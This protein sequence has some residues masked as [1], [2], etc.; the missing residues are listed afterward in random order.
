VITADT[1]MMYTPNAVEDVTPEQI[2]NYLWKKTNGRVFPKTGIGA[3][4][5]LFGKIYGIRPEVL[6]AQGTQEVGFY[7]NVS[8]NYRWVKNNNPAE[9]KYYRGAFDPESAPPWLN[10]ENTFAVFISKKHGIKSH[11]ER[12]FDYMPY[13]PNTTVRQFLNRWGTSH[14]SKVVSRANEILSQPK[15]PAPGVRADLTHRAMSNLANRGIIRGYEG[16]ML[17]PEWPLTRAEMAA[18]LARTFS[19]KLYSVTPAPAPSDVVGHWARNDI[20]LIIGAGWMGGYPD[21]TF[22]PNKEITRAEVCSILHRIGAPK[23]K[24]TGVSKFADV[25]KGDWFYD[26]VNWAYAN[27]WLREFAE[28]DYYGNVRFLPNFPISRAEMSHLLYNLMVSMTSTAGLTGQA[29]QNFVEAAWIASEDKWVPRWAVPLFVNWE[30]VFDYPYT[31]VPA[32]QVMS[33]SEIIARNPLPL[34]IGGAVSAGLLAY[35]LLRRY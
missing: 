34:I 2:D 21:G 33:T 22:K 9:M 6:V 27:G 5:V 26:S 32:E 23:I 1:L 19:D 12:A 11:F 24:K 7:Q 13:G 35:L 28:P 10:K 17:R 8:W 14:V 20:C 29:G 25:K 16:G 18:L 30:E 31:M 15:L 3:N 4:Y